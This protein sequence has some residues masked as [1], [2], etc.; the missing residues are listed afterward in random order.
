MIA[1]ALQ[2]VG[3]PQKDIPGKIPI[4]D[5]QIPY[6]TAQDQNG[7]KDREDSFQG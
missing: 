5:K 7:Q 6:D 4:V 1:V 3:A 2:L